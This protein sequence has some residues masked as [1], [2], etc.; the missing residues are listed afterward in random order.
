[1]KEKIQIE[2]SA[3][4]ILKFFAILIG[5]VV[6]YLIRDILVTFFLVAVLVAAF[7]PIV[8]RLEK[9]RVPRV[10]SVSVI[11]FIFLAALVGIGFLIIP[12]LVS[13]LQD[14]SDNL[15]YFVQNISPK[16]YSY[17]EAL[18]LSQESLNQLSQTFSS[19]SSQLYSTTVGFVSGV[20]SIITILVVSFYLLIDTVSVKRFFVSIFPAAQ[21][22]WVVEAGKKITIKMGAWLGGQLLLGLII[23][24]LDLVI[25]VSFGV[26]YAL[27]L[28]IWGGLTEVVPFIGP[29]LGGI[30][31]VL[32][33]WSIS[34]WL[35]LGV[36][37]AY[38]VIQQLEAQ[39]LAP[40]VMGKAV[41][42][43][44][45][46]I[47]FAILVGAKLYGIIGII[48]AIPVAAAIAVLLQEWPKLKEEIREE[49]SDS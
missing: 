37:I 28:A 27:T 39:L 2:I 17:R 29:W 4:T 33:A 25:L 32:V 46:I 40:R 23:G 44:P 11:Y 8:D 9:V 7:Y 12:P 43:S 41:G 15:P 36:A 5:L 21:K 22:Q 38:I 14:L 18:K 16:L 45:V 31:A 19:V 20:V 3:L 6:L 34:P 1:M 10:L 48:I 26:P 13:Q 35:A 24:V 49:K 47:I 30:P 42:L